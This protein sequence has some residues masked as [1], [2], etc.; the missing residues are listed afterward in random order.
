MNPSGIPDDHYRNIAAERN[1]QI[2]L[3]VARAH[4]A[5]VAVTR[6]QVGRHFTIWLKWY[7]G[8]WAL[9]R[10]L[11]HTGAKKVNPHG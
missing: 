10:V 11:A 4:L 7:Q 3:I 5:G 8:K 1:R 2:S 9:G 6:Q